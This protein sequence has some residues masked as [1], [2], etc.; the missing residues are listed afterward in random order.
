MRQAP[1]PPATRPRRTE[2][3]NNGGFGNNINSSN[4]SFARE[5]ERNPIVPPAI[6][7]LRTENNNNGGFGN[8]DINSGNI[9]PSNEDRNPYATAQHNYNNRGLGRNSNQQH[10]QPN[11][12]NRPTEII[13]NNVH[14]SA[15]RQRQLEER[16]YEYARMLREQEERERHRRRIIAQGRRQIDVVVSEYNN[17]IRRGYHNDYNTPV[18]ASAFFQLNNGNAIGN[19]LHEKLYAIPGIL[20]DISFERRIELLHG[21]VAERLLVK[22]LCEKFNTGEREE[23]FK[24]ILKP[25]LNEAVKNQVAQKLTTVLSHLA[26][27]NGGNQISE[28]QQEKLMSHRNIFT[29]F[30]GWLLSVLPDRWTQNISCVQRRTFAEALKKVEASRVVEI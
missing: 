28:A 16:R 30:L 11:N 5:E 3:N 18:L 10:T 17:L 26:Q 13:V 19:S 6:R 15:D 1:I 2:N 9:A 8:N 27:Q 22:K 21:F 25:D 4:N 20:E 23:G 24:T 7:P 14:V 29:R 12:F